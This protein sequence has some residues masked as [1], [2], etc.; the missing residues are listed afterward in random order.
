[1]A[2][3]YPF[4]TLEEHFLAQAAR[5]F[6]TANGTTHPDD[7]DSPTL[8]KLLAIGDERLTSMNDSGVAIQVISHSP[9]SLA[10][11]LATCENVNNELR[12]GIGSS[13][14]FRGFATLPMK[15]P[16]DASKELRRC[17]KELGFLGALIDSNCEGKFYDD[18]SYWPVFEAAVDLDVPIYLHPNLNEQTKPLLY[19]G[20][21]SESVATSLSRYGWGWH[22][23]TAIHFLRLF[24]AGLFDAYPNLKLVLGHL[25]EML[26]FQLDRIEGITNNQWPTNKKLREVW[27]EN[28]WITSAGMFSLAP[29]AA[30][31]RQS[32][33]ARI[34]FSVDYPFDEN[35]EGLDFMTALKADGLV[36]DEVLEGIAYKN[37]ES[38]LKVTVT[39]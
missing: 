21:Y 7:H 24:G 27:N 18:R 19:D 15:Y 1:M 23:E 25:G 29:M 33:P 26:P 8:P 32:K 9:N 6:Y 28:V 39:H 34:L 37:A 11:D 20:N 16:E 12:D 36:S 31:V 17:V 13:D 14:R 35:K 4:I 2:F 22:S 3:P 5:D 30:V 10:L 38:L